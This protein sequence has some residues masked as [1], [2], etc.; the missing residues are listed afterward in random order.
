[1]RDAGGAS[2]SSSDDSDLLALGKEVVR[3]L[4][5]A[6]K[7][8]PT[9]YLYDSRG[10][11]LFEK[12]TELDEY[13]QT[14]TETAILEACAEAWVSDLKQN[15][16]LVEFGS[17]SSRKTEIVLRASSRITH[18][19]PIDVS[20]SAVEDAVKRLDN[21]FPGLVVVP[22]VGDFHDVTLPS[23]LARCSRAGFFPGSTIGNLNPD[24]AGCLLKSFARLLGTESELLI[25]VDLQKP[26]DRLLRAYDDS[27]GVTA[28]FN[29]NLLHRINRELSG[30]FDVEAFEH[31]AVYN[32]ELGR[33]EMHI[34]SLCDQ[35]VDILGQTISFAEGE[36]IH[37][38]NSYKYTVDGFRGLAEKAG[39]ATKRTWTD[40]EN[41]F[42]VHALTADLK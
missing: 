17:G 25:G 31:L 32:H 16:V 15:T 3:G 24:A 8:L 13:Y 5:K 19:A 28:A 22:I 9:A 34:V 21:R 36:R 29:L 30:N 35:T 40:P 20:P 10:S 33:I 18:Y 41:L 12:I 1:M 42:S 26:V 39:W 11:A 27:E 14:R 38:E 37:T 7:T 23:S 4:S 2:S 6:E